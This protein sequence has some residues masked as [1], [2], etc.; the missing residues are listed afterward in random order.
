V[1]NSALP[2]IVRDIVLLGLG[3]V[4][5]AYMTF[6]GKVYLPLVGAAMACLGLTAGFGLK[7][8]KDGKPETQPTRE[9]SPPSPSASS[10][11]P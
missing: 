3:A 11:T 9:P 1:K 4:M 10:P 2:P 5:L 6:T 8:L 7:S